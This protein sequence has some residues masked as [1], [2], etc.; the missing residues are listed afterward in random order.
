MVSVYERLPARALIWADGNIEQLDDARGAVLLSGAPELARY[1]Q[2]LIAS[3][4]VRLSFAWARPRQP[5]VL[6]RFACVVPHY[7]EQMAVMAEFD[8]PPAA[9]FELTQRELDVLTLMSAGLSNPEISDRLFA[10][11]A[12]VS[13]HVERILSKLGQRSRAGA[14]AVALEQG[15]LRL[16]IPGGPGGFDH[17]AIGTVE[18]G[19]AATTQPQNG[20]TVRKQPPRAGRPLLVGAI[21]PTRER[22]SD[23]DE[24]LNGAELAI[25][26]HNERGGILGRALD[27]VIVDVSIDD[28]ASIRSGVEALVA[29]EVDVITFGYCW[30]EDASIY[31][32]ATD[33]GCPILTSMVSEA[34]ADWVGEDPT[35]FAQVFQ[36][37]STERHYGAGFFRM[38]EEI[39]L[40]GEWQPPNRRIMCVETAVAAGQ[41]LDDQAVQLGNSLGWEVEQV[42][43]VDNADADWS[44]ALRAIHD[45]APAAV[46]VSHFV[47]G[48]LARFQR[49]FVSD[50][51]D[52]VLHCIYAPSVPVYLELAGSAADGVVWSTEPNSAADTRNASVSPRDSH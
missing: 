37:S 39:Q 18:R 51:R 47:P 52:T 13:T 16:P 26:E 4:H 31:R 2:T 23:R 49:L 12:T 38:L 6:V 34:Q 41:F 33:Y 21:A 43:R 29:A 48:E 45:F 32:S 20:R 36:V 25:S 30:A 15:L 5:W 50:P 22:M 8:V 40:A 11:R 1:A 46:L 35:A 17:L 9:P 7:D 3:D 19:V 27:P 10:S 44:E 24:M 28:P 42:I 14:A